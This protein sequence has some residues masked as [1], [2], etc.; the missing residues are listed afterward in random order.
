MTLLVD[1]KGMAPNKSLITASMGGNIV[2]KQL[3]D[4]TAGYQERGGQKTPLPEAEVKSKKAQTCLVEQVDY[5]TGDAFKLVA[6]G[7]SQVNGKDA[8]KIEVTTPSG[9]TQTEYYDVASKLLVR[10]ETALEMNGMA[11][12][13]TSDFGDY[14]KVGAILVPYKF[15]QTIEAGGQQQA[16]EFV[17]TDVKLNEGVTDADFK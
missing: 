12:N 2:D 11:L 1:Q 7:I 15:T 16:M 17:V 5:V 8:Y 14:R 3:F 9:K 6:K 13:Q 10:S 4:G